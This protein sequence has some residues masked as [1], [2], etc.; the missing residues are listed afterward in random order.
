MYTKEEKKELVRRFWASFD[1]YCNNIPLLAVKKRKW[2]LH[3]TKISN[4]SLK[5]ETGRE[6]ARVILEIG[7]RNEARRLMVYEIFEKYKVILEQD[8]PEGLIWDFAFTRDNGQPVCRIYSQLNNVDFHRQ[9]QW[10][11]I[12]DF[13]AKNMHLL[14]NNFLEIRDIVTEEIRASDT[15]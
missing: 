15:L 14:E 12:F 10:P 4:V 9:D 8:F 5:F 7:H 1:D 13:F 3:K 2:I 6:N 11:Q